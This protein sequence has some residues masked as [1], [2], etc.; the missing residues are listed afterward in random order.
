MSFS[1]GIV[2]LPNVGKSTLFRFLTNKQVA[3]ENY[4]FCTIDP[5]VGVVSVPD[6]RLDAL[7]KVSES[8][9]IIP[10]I[11]EFVDIAGLVKGA[12]EGQG[13]GNKFLSHIKSVDAIAQ[14][15]RA[16]SAPEVIHVDGIINPVSDV[17]V[18][19]LELILA[20]ADVATKRL[21]E[22]EGKAR[23]GDKE[24]KEALAVLQ[25]AYSVLQQERFL[26]SEEWS[27]EEKKV[28]KQFNF[29][30]IKPMF[31][32]V[33]ADDSDDPGI[34]L[35]G[36]YVVVP[37]LEEPDLTSLITKAYETL[38]LVSFFTTGP[39]ETRAWT[40]EQGSKAPQAAGVIHTDFEKG[41]IR[42][43]VVGW[44]DLVELGSIAEAK[45]KGVWRLEGKDYVI[46]DGDVCHFRFA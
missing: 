26:S 33:N 14:V 42:A 29:L 1:V 39:E 36:P 7:S 15:V 18:I 46:Q 24:S 13:L 23:T 17:T 21:K 38:N 34:T 28:L 6:D 45:S 11:I 40:V 2:G 31:Y 19:N 35:P 9:K 16:F 12:H 27:L 10:T 37:L 32:V 43:E 30:T 22:M 3:C 20:D 41:F 44:K 25:K 8:K 5:N 4:P